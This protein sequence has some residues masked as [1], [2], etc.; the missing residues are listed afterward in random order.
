MSKKALKIN[1]EYFLEAKRLNALFDA[2]KKDPIKN[3][4]EHPQ[5]IDLKLT[6]AQKVAF[7]CIF[8]QPLDL[9]TKWNVYEEIKDPDGNFDLKYKYMTEPDIYELMTG[10][11]YRER[12][13]LDP[14]RSI[15]R[16]NLIVGRRGGKTTISSVLAIYYAIIQNWK[17]FL[18][19]TP[20]ATVLIL[21]HSKEFSEEIMD[22]MKNLISSSPIL[23]RLLS[24]RYKN[25]AT[26]INLEVPFIQEDGSLEISRV[27]IKVGAASSKTTRG[28]ATCVALCDEIAFWNLDE[29]MKETDYKIVK[30]V[31]PSL[32]QFKDK[33]LLIKLSSPAIKQGV[34]YDEHKKW[35]QSELPDNFIVFKAPSWVWNTILPRRNFIDEWKLDAQSFDSEYRAN[36][37]DSV[38]DFLNAQFIDMCRMRGTNFE[39]PDQK[40]KKQVFYTAAIDA[41]YKGDTFTFSVMGNH[42]NKVKQYVIQGWEGSKKNPVKLSEVAQY[43]RTMCKEYGINQVSADQ[44]SFEPLRELFQ[45]YG[46][47]LVERTF[48]NTFKKKI[49]FNLKRLINAQQIDL[50]DH[51]KL[52]RELKEINVSQTGT[53]Q[54]KIGHPTGGSDDY[55][56]ATAISAWEAIEMSNKLLSDLGDID[57]MAGDNDYNIPLDI[58]GNAFVAPS[59]EMLGAIYGAEIIDNSLDFLDEEEE[60]DVSSGF[61]S[62]F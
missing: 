42:E 3:F 2:I 33:G 62:A 58:Y 56:D 38:S 13:I 57:V 18:T 46:I 16:V 31:S 61:D 19:K 1:N 40:N 47:T 24:K 30:A 53:G 29:D 44:Y 22:L 55:A 11:I 7:K 32:L 51:D 5:F 28:K 20:Y 52:I 41:A 12:H 43:I 34:L 21:S 9:V 8:K 17:P 50:L 23:N 15:N 4:I 6:A 48:T 14:K 54:I 49:Y 60:D 37:V 26:T 59:P 36:F 45:T 35:E 27:Q 10:R 25:T 39:P